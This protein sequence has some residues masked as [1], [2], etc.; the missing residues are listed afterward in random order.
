MTTDLDLKRLY[1]KPLG[2]YSRDELN[3]IPQGACIINLDKHRYGGTHWTAIYR[4]NNVIF[5][6]DSFGEIAPEKLD[7][8]MT[9]YIFNATDIQGL[10]SSSCGQYCVAFLKYMEK[11]PSIKRFG[12]FLGLFN[13]HYLENEDILKHLNLSQ[14]TK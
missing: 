14:S 7:R 8:L 11:K 3:E 5:Y 4:K 2:I 9:P 10:N 6:F 13:N 12:D 1:K